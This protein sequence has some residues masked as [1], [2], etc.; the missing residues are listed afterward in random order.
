MIHDENKDVRL[1]SKIAKINQGNK[2]IIVKRDQIIEFG[3]SM[4]AVGFI[5]L[6]GSQT[7]LII[8]FQIVG[9]KVIIFDQWDFTPT[10][11]I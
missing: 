10:T 11:S 4:I 3:V 5:A 6:Y 8:C 9:N 1:L 2:S 7:C